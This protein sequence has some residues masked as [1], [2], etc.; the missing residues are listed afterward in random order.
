MAEE[1]LSVV[2]DIC[3]SLPFAT[4]RLSHGTPSW[5]VQDKRQFAAFWNNHHGDGRLGLW[6]AAPMGSQQA[7]IA[8]APIWFFVPPY[9][10]HRGWIGVLLDKGLMRE[11]LTDL[12]ADAYR[13]V[14]PAKLAAILDAS[15][16]DLL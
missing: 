16:Q 15:E 7:L 10:A 5:F 13:T 1:M 2:R 4:E 12:I 11:E 9:V 14:A 6:M 8:E 3:M